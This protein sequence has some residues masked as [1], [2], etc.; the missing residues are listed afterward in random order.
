MLCISKFECSHATELLDGSICFPGRV[1]PRACMRS[2]DF[3]VALPGRADRLPGLP[4]REG[5]RLRIRLKKLAPHGCGAREK[6]KGEQAGSQ[7]ARRISV[8]D[9]ISFGR[10]G[11]GAGMGAWQ[12]EKGNSSSL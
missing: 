12:E 2:V 10:F 9:G 3:R 7:A 8:I 6:N 11:T 1:R 5:T 4:D